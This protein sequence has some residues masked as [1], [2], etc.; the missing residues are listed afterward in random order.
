MSPDRYRSALKHSHT[1]TEF[2][3]RE[4]LRY[5]RHIQLPGFGAEGQSRLKHSR[6]LVIGC[7]GL[8][9]PLLL[10]LTAAG[11]GRL[12]LVDD[13]SVD[14]TNLQRQILYTENDLGLRKA[15]AAAR[16]LR[17]LNSDIEVVVVGESFGALDGGGANQLSRER[18]LV[19]AHDLVVDCTDNFAGRY[20]INDLC[21]EYGKPWVYA[22]VFQFSGQCALF[23]PGAGC[24]RCLFP[25]SPE[26]LPDCNSAGVLGAIPGLLGAIQANE[27]LKYLAGLP[28]PLAGNLLL[29]EAVDLEF[30]RVELQRDPTCPICHP[31]DVDHR[32]TSVEPSQDPAG[33]SMPEADAIEISVAAFAHMAGEAFTLLDVRGDAERQAFHIGGQHL[34][35]AAI[36]EAQRYLPKSRPIICYCQSGQR[37]LAA[38]RLLSEAGYSARSLAG[39]L[40]AWLKYQNAQE[41]KINDK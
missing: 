4:W 39:G 38:A 10:Y 1:P 29:V 41:C 27:V 23:Q 7:G 26:G 16:R 18:A 25:E 40:V 9:S 28:T 2:A 8:G 21:A 32:T 33:Q 5:T 31:G 14:L 20:L 19:Q 36:A 22:S 34:A 35:L 11:V 6:V 12:T 3:A 13:D 37:S 24:F 15:Q 30:R 17:A